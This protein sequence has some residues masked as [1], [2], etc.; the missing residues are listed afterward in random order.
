M[1][2]VL[3]VGCLPGIAIFCVDYI[4]FR[5]NLFPFMSQQLSM[6]QFWPTPDNHFIIYGHSQRKS[7]LFDNGNPDITI[8]SH[9][10]LCRAKCMSHNWNA[11][12]MK[13]KFI[14]AEDELLLYIAWPLVKNELLF[15]V[16]VSG[17]VIPILFVV[18][19]VFCLYAYRTAKWRQDRSYLASVC[20]QSTKP[21]LS[22]QS[23]T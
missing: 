15:F 2:M 9:Y 8:F 21:Q 16:K 10:F 22:E 14:P 19:V 18:V 3:G 11:V 1:N 23:C 6:Q 5:L 13:A 4:P 7:N 20:T 17:R 12:S